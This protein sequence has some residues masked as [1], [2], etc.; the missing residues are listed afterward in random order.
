MRFPR[1]LLPRLAVWLN[2]HDL[3]IGDPACPCRLQDVPPALAEVVPLLDGYHGLTDLYLVCDRAW[4]DWLVEVLAA[5]DC[6]GEGPAARPVLDVRV[7]GQTAVA[8]RIAGLLAATLDRPGPRPGSPRLH[9]L[10]PPTAEADRVAVAELFD[11][12]QPHLI[13]RV[14]AHRA[15]VGPLVVPGVT[16]CVTCGDLA[17]R[18]LDPTWPLQVFQMSQTRTDPDPLLSAWAA[19]MA[20][21]QA[22]S[23]ARGLVPE[24]VATTIEWGDDGRILHRAWPAHPACGCQSGRA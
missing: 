24:T 10:A 8:R 2:P 5:Q 6:L 12:G 21:G 20:V 23:Y 9:I 14:D 11:R 1:L 4:V 17:R 19:T 16:S 22:L 18:D 3:Q 15:S 13:V 7:Q